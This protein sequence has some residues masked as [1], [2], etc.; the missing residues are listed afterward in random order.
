VGADGPSVS[1]IC[2]SAIIKILS[3]GNIGAGG[4]VISGMPI[5]ALF[6][7]SLCVNLAAA[8]LPVRQVILY[9]HGVGFFERSGTLGAGETARLDFKAEEMNDVLKSLTVEEKGGGK[10]SALRYDSSIPLEEKLAEYPISIAAGQPLT[11]LLDQLKGAKVEITV[12]SEKVAGEIVGARTIAG[13]K[14][15]REQQQVVLLLDSG[16]LRTIE[17][18]ATSSVHFPD[19]KIQLQFRDYLAALAGARSKDKRSLYLDSTDAR[20]REVSASYIIPAPVWKSSYRLIFDNG[21]PT[22][23]GWAIV[24]NTTGEDWTNVRMSLISGKPI[25]FISELY[26]PKYI[27]RQTADLAEYQ[28]IAPTVYSGGVIGGIAGGIPSAAP[29]PPP[30]PAQRMFTSMSPSTLAMESAAPMRLGGNLSSLQTNTESRELGDLF[31]YTIG[32]P[33]TVRKNQSAMLPFLQQKITGRKLTIYSDAS[34]QN[35]FNAAELTNSTNKTLDG[36]PITVFDAGSYAGEAL[37]ETVKAN[38]KRL[39]NYAV[40]LGTRITA[41]LDS[42]A[43]VVREIHASRGVMTARYSMNETKTFT[44]HNVDAKAKTLIIEHP[45]RPQYTLLS[46]KPADATAKAYRFEVKLAPA[47]T[48][49]FPVE[50][51]RVYSNTVMISSLSPG[52]TLVYLENKTLSDAGRRTL[53]QVVDQRQQIA[54]LD[55]QLKS[56]DGQINNLTRDQDRTRQNISSLNSVNGQQQQVDI[57]ARKLADQENQL[58]KLRDQQ[59]DLQRKRAAA[60]S[61]LD[62]FMEK[63]EF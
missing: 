14:D 34:M 28:A 52:Q 61:S 6:A 56:V 33:V 7:V 5:R 43:Q 37:V 54:S 50:E 17:L 63:I 51:E 60:Q 19:P 27:Q 8:E 39:I 26:E 48:Q 58:A 32:T 49:K 53:Q 29:P 3:R 47:S 62:A 55:Q 4:A 12:G 18:A 30:A 31:E 46:A 15:R 44:I 57:Y 25:S 45:I 20:S 36:G 21:Q 1:P 16:D 11:T 24:D 40:D 42:K 13:D 9:K 23:E 41:A 2:T 35:P 59:T 10:V 22:L 38:D